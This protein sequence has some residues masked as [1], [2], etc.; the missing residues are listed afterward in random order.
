[1][2]YA[3]FWLY[4]LLHTTLATI[5]E[6]SNPS[7]HYDASW[8]TDIN[9]YYSGGSA[10]HTNINGGTANYTFTGEFGPHVPC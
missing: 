2:V 7:I 1:M 6:D 10:H 5:V 4:L 3:I 8:T 9:G